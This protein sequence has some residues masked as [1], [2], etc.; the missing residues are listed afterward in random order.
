MKNANVCRFLTPLRVW[1]KLRLYI[2]SPLYII[3]D[4]LKKSKRFYEKNER[5][6]KNVAFFV[7]D[8]GFSRQFCHAPLLKEHGT[9]D[10][11]NH[12]R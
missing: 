2:T 11:G 7:R 4:N 10:C 8:R 1:A 6:V 3:N 12:R 9:H 5:G